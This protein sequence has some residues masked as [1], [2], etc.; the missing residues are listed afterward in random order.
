MCIRMISYQRYM[1]GITV[2]VG[3]IGQKSLHHGLFVVS[4]RRFIFEDILAE[5]L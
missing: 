4:L 5:V 1:R 2:A 3:L